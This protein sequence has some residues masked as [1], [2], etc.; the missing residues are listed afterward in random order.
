MI[1]NKSIAIYM[2]G[3]TYDKSNIPMGSQYIWLPFHG[4]CRWDLLRY[5]ESWDWLIPVIDKIT[6]DK[7]Y[8]KYVDY[9]SSM[10]EQGG[11]YINTKYIN[12]TYNNVIDFIDWYNKQQKEMN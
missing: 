9:S 1:N 5:H 8:P 12:D 6:S 7:A 11:V 2:G 4:V 10:I 3:K